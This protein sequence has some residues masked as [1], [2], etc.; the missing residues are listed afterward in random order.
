MKTSHPDVYR[1]KIKRNKVTFSA[2]VE[3]RPVCYF[4]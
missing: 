4:K 2:A 1:R 3:I